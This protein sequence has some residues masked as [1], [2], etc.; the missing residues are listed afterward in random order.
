MTIASVIPNSYKVPG[1][2]LKVT[3]GVGPRSAGSAAIKVALLGNMLSTGTATI[4]TAY[5]VYSEQDAITLFGRGSELHQL[6][7]RVF[8]VNPSCAL[9]CIA[10]TE[11][12]GAKA[13]QTITFVGNA[14][15][16]GAVTVQVGDYAPITVAVN[17]GDTI[18]AIASAV[19]AAINKQSDWPVTSTPSVGVVTVTA[20]Q[21]G[22]RG[23]YIYLAAVIDA[24]LTTTCAVGAA[25]LAAGGATDS[26]QV[27]LDA[28]APVRYNLIVA[29]Y[30]TATELAMFKAH[31]NT[32][33]APLVGRRELFVAC[34]N[35][36]LGSS[37]TVSDGLNVARGRVLWNYNSIN[38]PGESAAAFA[39]YYALKMG[40]DRAYN[41]DGAVIPTLAPQI[42]AADYPLIDT[43][44]D[45]A[46]NAGLIPLGVSSGS[47]NIVRAITNYHL[48]S[49]TNP[50]FNVLDAHKCD[51]P[52][53]VADTLDANFRTTFQSEDNGFKLKNDVAGEEPAPG[54]ATPLTLKDWAFPI[55]V[56]LE[57][58]NLLKN[59][60]ARKDQIFFEIDP[61]TNGRVNALIP[62]DVIDL[63]HQAG[64]DVRQVG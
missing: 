8:K 33:A 45:Q 19:S 20:R 48:D 21:K 53:F 22:L 49:G 27:A 60:E 3:L 35:V 11:S 2:F 46:L 40:S 44:C 1:P 32:D 28:I 16:S 38:T 7:R 61:Q 55:L 26:P 17:S 4:E 43:E 64:M 5:P 9:T 10:V 58:Q 25:F 47:M 54:V 51:V 34:L 18:T 23:N 63:L 14:G 29:P 42:S 50:D 62:C 6:A 39:A 30:Q 52:D 57:R 36:A 31:M 24:G 59:V 37:I 12:A 56:D 13:A 15:A 41:Y